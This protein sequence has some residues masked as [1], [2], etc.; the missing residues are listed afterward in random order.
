MNFVYYPSRRNSK[1]R[2]GGKGDCS[3]FYKLKSGVPDF[4]K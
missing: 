3:Q 2:V 1:K 4:K